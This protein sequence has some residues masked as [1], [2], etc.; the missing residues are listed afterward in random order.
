MSLRIREF[1]ITVL[2]I[3]ATVPLFVHGVALAYEAGQLDPGLNGISGPW[4]SD[5]KYYIN[6][7]STL[8]GVC[9]KRYAL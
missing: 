8:T 6:S 1:G 3:C 2:A 4:T 5:G 7:T 9:T